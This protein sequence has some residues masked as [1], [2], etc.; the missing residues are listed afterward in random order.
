MKSKNIQLIYFSA[1]MAA[2][3]LL[4]VLPGSV[5]AQNPTRPLHRKLEALAKPQSN[6]NWLEFREGTSINPST[7]F[8]DLKDAF[9]LSAMTR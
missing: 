6:R 8:T 4:S 2:I 7:I 9:E 5:S 3:V 1:A